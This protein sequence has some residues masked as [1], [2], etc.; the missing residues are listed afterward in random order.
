MAE[1]PKT[2][3][4]NLG[5][6][7]NVSEFGK[8]ADTQLRDIVQ[9]MMRGDVKKTKGGGDDDKDN[10]AQYKKLEKIL[11][12]IEDKFTDIFED[13]KDFADKISKIYKSVSD[14]AAKPSGGGGGGGKKTAPIKQGMD[15][16]T[17]A[18]EDA[19]EGISESLQKGMKNAGAEV[20][21]AMDKVAD[22]IKF[23]TDRL[24]QGVA[25]TITGVTGGLSLMSI[26][27]GTVGE[28]IRFERSMRKTLLQTQGI[29]GTVVHMQEDLTKVGD[30]VKYTGKMRHKFLQA[31]DKNMKKGIKTQKE[32]L[33]ITRTGLGLSTLIG[34]E[35]GSTAELMH[36]WAMMAGQTSQQMG[37]LAYQIRD[38]ARTTG[39]TGEAL[40][41]IVKSSGQMVKNFRNAGAAGAS[42]SGKIIGMQAAAS[43]FGAT[44]I[45]GSSMISQAS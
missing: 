20:N 16:D 15:I 8:T 25:A 5:R 37:A 3:Q 30:T 29:G 12:K 28:S 38:V 44:E 17:D 34:D 18:A 9:G 31:F 13:S 40:A 35:T 22:K 42:L 21:K 10:S 1:T 43:K 26:F 36:E 27:E 11:E 4:D 2:A 45:M 7:V 14:K 23:S 19:V 6:T 24:M 32:T 33:K 41:N 39:V